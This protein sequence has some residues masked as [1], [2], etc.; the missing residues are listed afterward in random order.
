MRKTLIVA[1]TALILGALAGFG[2]PASAADTTTTFTITGG[3]LSL[4]AP[5]TGSLTGGTLG[6]TATGQLG[7]VTVTDARAA[8]GG[9][10]AVT[11]QSTSFTTGG[12]TAAETIAATNVSYWSGLAT[13]TG[14]ATFLPGQVAALNAVAIDT[15]KTAYSASAT[16]GNNSAAW[17]PT[18][19]VTVPVQAVAGTYTGTITHS[20]A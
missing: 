19:V 6:G 12:K 1:S 14:V 18:V 17:N 10:W 9:S 7:T 13:T 15:A 20:L 16:A 2:S 4:T 11:A 8:L 5:A 3:G